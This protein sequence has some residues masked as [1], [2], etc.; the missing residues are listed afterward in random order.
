VARAFWA[1]DLGAGGAAASSC[2]GLCDVCD[3]AVVF[4]A[5]AT[6]EL[7]FFAGALLGAGGGGGGTTES[8]LDF[9]GWR[10]CGAAVLPST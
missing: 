4:G 7:D 3:G 2:F 5:C 9:G 10:S 6:T 1:V 8:L